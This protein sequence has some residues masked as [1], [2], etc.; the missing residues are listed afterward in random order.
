MDV[1]VIRAAVEVEREAV[2]VDEAGLVDGVAEGEDAGL[3]YA[4]VG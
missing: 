2:V 1:G 4:L 3:L